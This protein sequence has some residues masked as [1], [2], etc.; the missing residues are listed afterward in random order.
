[1]NIVSTVCRRCRLINAAAATQHFTQYL[2]LSVHQGRGISQQSK[3]NFLIG[4]LE[5]C[6]PFFMNRHV[7]SAAQ[8]H[9]RSAMQNAIDATLDEHLGARFVFENNLF[10]LWRYIQFW[11]VQAWAWPEKI[12]RGGKILLVKKTKEDSCF[13]EQIFSD[14]KKGFPLLFLTFRI[15]CKGISPWILQFPLGIE[16]IKKNNWFRRKGNSG[17][18]GSRRK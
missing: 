12:S 5:F 4:Q 18:K 7:L 8:Y 2:M 14:R 16:K 11:P 15:S 13:Y 10:F 6:R 1:M 3:R 17:E 9:K